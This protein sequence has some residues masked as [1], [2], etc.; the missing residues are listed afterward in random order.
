[1]FKKFIFVI[2]MLLTVGNMQAG[3][4][5]AT[6]TQPTAESE[7]VAARL[8]AASED[9]YVVVLADGTILVPKEWMKFSF[10]W[11]W[12]TESFPPHY[13]VMKTDNP[14]SPYKLV[15]LDSGEE[16][17]LHELQ[18]KNQGS[19]MFFGNEGYVLETTTGQE[20]YLRAY[21]AESLIGPS[22]SWW[23]LCDPSSLS[24]TQSWQPGDFIFAALV[25]L[26]KA[27]ENIAVGYL[28]WR[29]SSKEEAAEALFE[30]WPKDAAVWALPLETSE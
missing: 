11:K 14:E 12:S 7:N 8:I 27:D 13:I 20:F 23:S 21:Y 9:V 25:I 1:M 26:K 24:V 19:L 2:L 16:F 5:S 17:I 28:L 3:Q 15:I 10:S 22:Q 4:T 6:P 18:D 30:G 29:F